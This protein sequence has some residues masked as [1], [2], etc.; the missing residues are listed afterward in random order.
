MVEYVFGFE[1]LKVWQLAKA[2]AVHIYEVTRAFP[3]D[4]KF[5]LISQLRRASISIASNLAE[6][7]ARQSMKHQAHFSQLAYSSLVEVVCQ[8]EIAL[9]LGFMTSDQYKQ[10]RSQASEL[11]YMINALQKSQKSP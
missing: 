6:G 7:S 11:S 1:K 2:F 5:G 10:I 8:L 9:E 4:E 3:P